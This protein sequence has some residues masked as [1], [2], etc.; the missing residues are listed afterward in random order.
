M[1]GS[2]TTDEYLNLLRRI[3]WF[4][5]LPPQ[6]AMDVEANVRRTMNADEAPE[7]WPEPIWFDTE[8][9][10]EPGDYTSLL[11]LFSRCSYGTFEPVDVTERWEESGDDESPGL[12]VH[13][14]FEVDGKRWERALVSEDA[15]VSADFFDLLD[16]VMESKGGGLAF[17]DVDTGDQTALFFLCNGQALDRAEEAGL[18]PEIS[19]ADD[20]E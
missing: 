14:G 18:L 4:E 12:T 7:P 5:G 3:G 11:A 15:W 17:G 2:M 20:D 1:L 13:L 8:C 19:P 10:E 9:I 16:D 6:A